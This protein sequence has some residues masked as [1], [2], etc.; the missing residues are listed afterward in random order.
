MGDFMGAPE[1]SDSD[2]E[3]M[4]DTLATLVAG[5]KTLQGAQA[6]LTYVPAGLVHAARVLYEKRLN[7]IKE[8][9]DPDFLADKHRKVGF[10]YSGPRHDDVV[11]PTLKARLLQELPAKAVEG[12]DAASSMVIG[13]GSPP[14]KETINTR[15]LVL[16]YVQSGKTTNF[17]SVVAKAADV[18]Y[19][20]IIV[21]TGTTENLRTQTQDRIN[22]YLIDPCVSIWNPL[23]TVDLDFS[24]TTS[25]NAILSNPS[26]RSIAVVK[27]NPSRL[28]RLR[29]WIK[30]AS[31]TTRQSC[32]ILIIDDEADQA[33]IDVGTKRQSTINGLIRDLL[34]NPKAA[35]IAYTATPFANLLID[36]SVEQDLYPRDFIVDLPRPDNYFG[37]ERIFGQLEAESLEDPV[38]DGLDVVRLISEL[39]VDVVRPPRNKTLFE[40]WSPD[41]PEAMDAAI[42]WFLLATA[43]RRL[44]AGQVTHSS[45]LIHTSMLA[46]AHEKTAEA[47]VDH[48]DA[49]RAEL[50]NE[51]PTAFAVFR[52]LW[53]SESVRVKADTFGNEPLPFD[54]LMPHLIET[55]RA[56]KVIVDNYKSNDRL[57][58]DKK[59]PQTAIVIGGNT[60]SRGLTLEG[61]TASY[62]VRASS[63]YDT[64]LQMGRWFGYRMGYED[65]IRIW[66]S[67]EL[68]SWF[69]MLSI[70]EAEI[71]EEIKVYE[72]EGKTPAELP[73]K[74]RTHPQ[75][76]VTSAAKMRSAVK[77]QVSYSGRR[78][79]TIMFN[80]GDSDWLNGN[81]T[82]TKNLFGR[83]IHQGHD[84]NELE[85]SRR[86][87]QDVSADDILDF[88]DAY[89]VHDAAKSIDKDAIRRYIER[90]RSEGDLKRWDVVLMEPLNGE[91]ELDLGLVGKV[92]LLRRKKMYIPSDDGT[93][94]LK[95]IASTSDRVA[96]LDVG[97]DFIRK[98]L[99]LVSTDKITDRQ[100][101]QFR[102]LRQKSDRKGLLCIYPI[103]KDSDPRLD[104]SA[105]E[106]AESRRVPL[107][108]AA[109]VIGLCFMFPDSRNPRSVVDYVAAKV[110]A[111]YLEALEEELE[112][113][114][115]LDEEKA[116][117][118]ELVKA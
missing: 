74:I 95:A 110:D 107:F 71:R 97:L 93:A 49:L 21:L 11:W 102:Q 44:R 45:M 67:S 63:A 62:F 68:K 5:G 28:R 40:Q 18:G 99:N 116:V 50:V 58:Y 48:L 24:V 82:A 22:D 16:G 114:D 52:D 89:K 66:M 72:A 39:E 79:Q 101:L 83:L 12:V 81:I 17:M 47:V 64:L 34:G 105:L 117:Q 75:M 8:I 19:R 15:G 31:A 76:S 106:P 4:A 98:S 70:V 14:G 60:L 2:V 84:E 85:A 29:N 33:S 51:A 65:L 69:L 53:D 118:E 35:Y 56:A 112:A 41:V 32:P 27:K 104:K 103:A 109:D 46:G 113:A 20:L 73:V 13:L 87:F 100:L 54:D 92:R 77:A 7:L 42:R 96:D 61:L 6:A 43:A 9:P 88:L 78:V 59:H 3:A 30:T 91:E 23:T 115:E 1:Y 25:A 55:A 86:G 111:D 38:D 10:W 108:A 26:M 36:P 94:N 37:A 80:E 57:E 90:E